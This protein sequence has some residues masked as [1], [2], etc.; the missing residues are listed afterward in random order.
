[1]SNAVLDTW[2]SPTRIY[3]A[4]GAASRLPDIVKHRPVLLVVDHWL[5]TQNPLI[6]EVLQLCIL[7]AVIEHKPCQQNLDAVI[8]V[9]LLLKTLDEALVVAIGGGSIMDIAKAGILLHGAPELEANLRSGGPVFCARSGALPMV[10]IPTTTGTAS[11]VSAVAMLRHND[12]ITMLISPARPAIALLDP[13]FI[14][15]V[16]E[17]QKLAGLVEPIAR[18]LIPAI[19]GEPLLL[20]DQLACAVVDTLLL[21]GNGLPPTAPD[22]TSERLQWNLTAA[23]ASA[24]THLGFL[25]LGRPPALHVLWPY[26]TELMVATGITKPMVLAR[27]IP[28]WHDLIISGSLPAAFGRLDRLNGLISAGL[29]SL[30]RVSEWCSHLELGPIPEFDPEVVVQRVSS[31]WQES[32]LFLPGVDSKHGILLLES[33]LKAG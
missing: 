25:G 13:R 21:L 2:F 10:A 12:R 29:P 23:L 20:Q 5:R 3:A 14:E 31:T 1:M 17:K 18:A 32:G 16:C 15:G 4:I 27:L 6:N 26:A 8:S 9:A 22:S 24:Q 33:L 30:E 19:V 28:V 7:G 11:E